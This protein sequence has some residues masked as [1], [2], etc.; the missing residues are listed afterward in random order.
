M[1][2][3]S[4]YQQAVSQG[5]I[6]NEPRQREILSLLQAVSDQMKK[7][8]HWLGRWRNQH[9]QGLYIYGPVGGGKTYLLDLFYQN[10]PIREKGRFHFHHFMQ[11]VDA[12]LR[13]RQGQVDPLQ[14]IARDFALKYKVLC[15]DEFLVHDV[16]YAMIL[17][18][19][20]QALF[21]Q[22]VVLVATSNTLPDELYL[23]GVQRARFLPAIAAIKQ[24]CQV[25]ALSGNRDFRLGRTTSLT[26]WLHPVTADNE[27]LMRQQFEQVAIQPQY[28]RTIPIQNRAIQV[29]ASSKNAVWFDFQV[30]CQMPRSQLD[31]L[32]LAQQYD[33][34]FISHVPVLTEKDTV[35]AILLIHLIDVLYDNHRRLIILS[36]T[37]VDCLYVK[38]E[39]LKEFARTRSRLSEMQSADYLR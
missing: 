13:Q 25:I 24:H 38:G 3:E 9:P 29:L 14:G 18:E 36:E 12:Q 2:L 15:F 32:E 37:T 33:T 1:D 35:A 8:R 5:K 6:Q 23:N 17:A 22:G 26:A 21:V 34:V 19:L 4:A 31:Y 16:A 7:K 20:L 30:I 27:A 10:L 11:Q 39:V 28:N